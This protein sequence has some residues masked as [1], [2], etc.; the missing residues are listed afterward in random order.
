MH[1]VAPKFQITN[2]GL[3]LMWSSQHAVIYPWF[4]L[5]D[6]GEDQDSLDADT[7]QRKVDTF[8]LPHD[9]K[10]KTVQWHGE[11]LQL[12]WSD[13]N[14]SHISLQRLKQMAGLVPE[15]E[16]LPDA[17]RRYYWLAHNLPDPYPSFAYPELVASE[18]AVLQ[19]LNAIVRYGFAVVTDVPSSEAATQTLAERI[20]PAQQTIFGIYW[21]LSAELKDHGDNAYST[22]FL[23]P[24]T[25]GTYYHDAAGLQMFNCLEFDGK[26]GESVVVD[27]FAIAEHMRL[28][29]PDLYQIL[30]EISVP[31][32]YLEPGVHLYAERPVFRLDRHGL[33]AQ[34]S[35]NN[36][37]RAPFLLPA[38]RMQAFYQAYAEFNRH[39][40][41]QANWLKIP[42]RPGM[43]LIFDNWRCLH[44]RMGYVGKRFFYGCYHGRADFESRLRVL[45]QTHAGAA[46]GAVMSG[47][48]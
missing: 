6:H 18:V 12:H 44:G 32:H 17:D 10:A 29:T 36:Y 15:S 45:A 37:D 21:P 43:A 34:V 26:G 35:F 24:H 3:T 1:S 41:N 20:A 14:A 28:N 30:T 9:I 40:I 47:Y 46:L 27:G 7:L 25:D 39:A 22:Q 11:M 33:L 8:A 16:A 31:G 48:R 19:W 2:D 5:R 4:W 13:G 38:E 42:L 23:A